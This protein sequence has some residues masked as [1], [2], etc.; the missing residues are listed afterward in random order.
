MAIDNS[1]IHVILVFMKPF[2][3]VLFIAAVF[4]SSFSDLNR[5]GFTIA[6]IVSGF[7]DSTVLFLD[8]ATGSRK[9]I[10]STY[11][12]SGQFRFT[13]SIKEVA[14]K[15]LIRTN[16]L[17][18]Y[19]FFWIENGAITFKAEKGKFR[20]A[21][22]SG[23]KT[24]DLENKLYEVIAAIRK[25]QD[26]LQTLL[27]KDSNNLQKTALTTQL[28][29][30]YQKEKAAYVQFIRN[31]P[32]SIISVNLLSIYATTWGKQ[33]TSELYDKLTSDVKNTSYGK[34][35][36][37]YISLN[38]DIRMGEPFVD[39]TQNNT[40]GK[41]VK[42]SDFKG[43]Y[44]LLEFWAAW[45]GPCRKENPE[46]VKTYNE[47]KDKGFEILGVSLDDQELSWKEAI[48]MDGL[49]WTNVSDLR[50]DKN[51]AALIYGITGV[52][53]NFLI[54]PEGKIIARNLRGEQLKNKLKELLP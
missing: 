14:Q 43:K 16:N 42:V 18:D 19:K 13:G 12:L 2:I 47:F 8:D 25:D 45:C 20:A 9:T 51:K 15:V 22:I 52:P 48:R 39:F 33:I 46:L 35:T 23:S 40:E 4:S 29:H 54:S 11:I 21:T 3:I 17:S 32:A 27:S 36:A 7:K 44:V 31:N 5:K 49:I 37:E 10:D 30:L 26:S 53:D 1:V 34:I 41:P 24:Q 6:G 38:Q 50:G 28:D